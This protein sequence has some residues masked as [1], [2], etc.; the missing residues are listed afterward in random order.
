MGPLPSLWIP[1]QATLPQ[2]PG[3]NPVDFGTSTQIKLT[4]EPASGSSQQGDAAGIPGSWA[5][6]AQQL[7]QP[8]GRE[9]AGCCAEKR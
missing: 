6:S 9:Q 8:P 2:A 3:L 1:A 4:L 5:P 7:L